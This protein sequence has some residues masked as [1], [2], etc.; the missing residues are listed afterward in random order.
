MVGTATSLTPQPPRSRGQLISLG[1]LGP[2]DRKTAAQLH[3]MPVVFDCE[4]V[5]VYY[6]AFRAVRGVTLRI[7][8][9]QITAFI[10]PSGCGKTTMLR[11]VVHHLLPILTSLEPSP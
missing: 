3:D 1:S 2:G 4:D 5:E 7:Q 6:G 8:E 9:H 10:G 11:S